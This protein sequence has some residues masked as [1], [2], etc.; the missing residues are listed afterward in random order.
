MVIFE[1]FMQG[2]NDVTELGFCYMDNINNNNERRSYLLG[3]ELK[4]ELMVMGVED[5]NT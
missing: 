5:E 1:S 4:R 3:Y 2:V